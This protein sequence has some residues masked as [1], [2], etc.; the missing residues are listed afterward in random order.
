LV[1]LQKKIVMYTTEDFQIKQL[2]KCSIPSPLQ[3]SKTQDDGIFNYI[4][5]DERILINRV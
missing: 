4:E 1:F 3:L 5:D 2:G